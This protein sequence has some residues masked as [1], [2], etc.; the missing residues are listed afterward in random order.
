MKLSHI[1]CIG[2]TWIIGKKASGDTSIGCSVVFY[3]VINNNLH[4]THGKTIIDIFE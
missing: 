4:K 1:L 2:Y 3:V